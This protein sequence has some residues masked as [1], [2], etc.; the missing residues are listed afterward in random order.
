VC[1]CARRMFVSE[2]VRCMALYRQAGTNFSLTP[3]GLLSL[4]VDT[5]LYIVQ[6][7]GPQH[8]L[9]VGGGGGGVGRGG[10]GGRVETWVI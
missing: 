4:C 6:K 2:R 9:C 8:Q 3:S 1:V 7:Q 10:G 5:N